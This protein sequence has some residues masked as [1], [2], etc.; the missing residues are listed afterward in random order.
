M[1]QVAIEESWVSSTD[2]ERI[3]QHVYKTADDALKLAKD[4]FTRRGI[5]YELEVDRDFLR[6]WL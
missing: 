2:D 4:E 6:V 3:R 5:E 1:V